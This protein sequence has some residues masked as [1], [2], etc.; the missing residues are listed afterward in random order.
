MD[1]EWLKAGVVVGSILY[2]LIGVLIF[3]LCFI[4]MDKLTPYKLWEEIIE[5]QNLALALVVAAMSLGICI[6]V[7]A[8]IH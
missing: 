4:V 1:I 2:A 3:G 7:A 8:A 6:I 5:K